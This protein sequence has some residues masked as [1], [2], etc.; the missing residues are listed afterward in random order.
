MR[1]LNN[2]PV[3]DDTQ[4]Q[5]EKYLLNQGELFY[6]S[7]LEEVLDIN[8]YKLNPLVLNILKSSLSDLDKLITNYKNN[9]E[10]SKQYGKEIHLVLTSLDTKLIISYL[11]GRVLKIISNHNQVN[12]KTISVNVAIDLA[13]D[14]VNYFI[15]NEFKKFNLQ[16]SKTK[17][18]EIN[19]SQNKY[20]L[21][22]FVSEHTEF[23]ILYT[24]VLLFTLGI[25]LLNFLEEVKLIKTTVVQLEKDVKQ[26]ILVVDAKIEVLLSN[27]P[28]LMFPINYP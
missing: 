11:L 18:T 28:L 23:D 16:M 7:K 26:T 4:I 15:S 12:K 22:K 19:Q 8:Y 25:N 9:V 20:T 27:Y 6:N 10:N 5:L 24:D 13:K 17:V 21:S 3:N 1:F 2:C 14:L